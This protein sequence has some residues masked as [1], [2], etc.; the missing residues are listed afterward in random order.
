MA[1]MAINLKTHA[2]LAMCWLS[3][4]LDPAPQP[5]YAFL[6]LLR[7]M[8]T[9]VEAR[10]ANTCSPSVLTPRNTQGWPK[11]CWCE[12]RCHHINR[13]WET[14]AKRLPFTTRVSKPMAF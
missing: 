8:S 1:Q 13:R 4:T 2:A 9:Q 3:L 11:S 6:D 7:V 5:L 12:N 10:M 14:R